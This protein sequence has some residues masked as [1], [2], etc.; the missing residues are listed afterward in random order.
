M[1]FYY[2]N[3]EQMSQ[4]E[5]MVLEQQVVDHV[6]A[7]AAVEDV[8]MSYEDA[9]KPPPP[10]VVEDEDEAAEDSASAGTNGDDE[11]EDQGERAD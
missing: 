2:Q 8:S 10:P 11:D 3:T 4:I 7:V 6:L 1:N 5:N 9:T